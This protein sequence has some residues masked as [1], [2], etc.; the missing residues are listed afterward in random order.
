MTTVDSY[1]L[2]NE[3]APFPF[4][5]RV[6]RGDGDLRVFVLSPSLNSSTSPTIATWF[7]CQKRWVNQEKVHGVI[8]ALYTISHK[9]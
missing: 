4:R 6:L 9:K 7:S 3:E 2:S 5:R 1:F 8:E